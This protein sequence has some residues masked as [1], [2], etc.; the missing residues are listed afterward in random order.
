MPSS[1]HRHVRSTNSKRSACGKR[2]L[3]IRRRLCLRTVWFRGDDRDAI[4]QFIPP[5]QRSHVVAG[6]ALVVGKFERV[7]VK[8]ALTP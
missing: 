6:D 3:I 1:S 8:D 7:E 5:V 4:Q 2:G